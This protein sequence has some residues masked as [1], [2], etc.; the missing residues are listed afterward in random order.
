MSYITFATILGIMLFSRITFEIFDYHKVLELGEMMRH[1]S[2]EM[3]I[4][5]YEISSVHKDKVLDRIFI[6][7]AISG[8]QY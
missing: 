3:E 7:N 6:D 4:F 5:M 8:I 2:E 1:K